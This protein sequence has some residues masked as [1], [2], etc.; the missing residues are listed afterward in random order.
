MYEVY[1]V[2]IACVIIGWILLVIVHS[3]YKERELLEKE[4]LEY[5]RLIGWANRLYPNCRCTLPENPDP[6]TSPDISKIII[7]ACDSDIPPVI[8]HNGLSYHLAKYQNIRFT[9]ELIK[10]NRD[11]RSKI[12]AIGKTTAIGK[13]EFPLVR[14]DVEAKKL[15]NA[16]DEIFHGDTLADKEQQRANWQQIAKNCDVKNQELRREIDRLQT[17]IDEF[18]HNPEVTEFIEQLQDY[19]SEMNENNENKEGGK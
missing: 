14:K 15:A 8:I 17:E 11:L 2:G 5:R 18:E 13:V 16:I 12:E 3:C 9:D 1:V 19:I 7:E 4:Q 10:Q 6:E